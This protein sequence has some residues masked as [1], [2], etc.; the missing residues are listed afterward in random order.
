MIIGGGWVGF[1]SSPKQVCDVFIHALG[2]EH[3]SVEFLRRDIIQAKTTLSV[4]LQTSSLLSYDQNARICQQKGTVFVPASGVRDA[5]KEVFKAR[6]KP[7]LNIVVDISSL[8][9]RLIAEV[10]VELCF[11]KSSIEKVTLFYTPQEFSD[12]EPN[13][14]KMGALRAITPELTAFDSDP[15]QPIALM[16]G[17]GFEY[18]LGL[19]LIDLIEPEQTIC[20]RATGFDLRYDEAVKSANFDFD[21]STANLLV[22]P[23]SLTDPLR[24]YSSMNNI[25]YGLL[26]SHRIEIVPLGPKIFSA[27][28]VLLALN[29]VGCVTVLRVPSTASNPRDAVARNGFVAAEINMT[30]LNVM[31]GG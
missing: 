23:Y 12:P 2:Y 8:T 6:K 30:A 11:H 14:A 7:S 19:G 21:F 26:A 20:F 4:A 18:G 5:I 24:A 29:F 10:L 16:L 25:A 22:Q 28:A 17:L 27:Y 1:E 3:R 15:D 31:G 9:R 13:F